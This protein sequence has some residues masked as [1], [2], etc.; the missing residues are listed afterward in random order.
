[1]T[2]RVLVTPRSLSESG[3]ARVPELDLL[4]ARGFELVN[5]PAGR[6]PEEDELLALLPGFSYDYT[7]LSLDADTFARTGS[8]LAGLGD[9]RCS[10]FDPAEPDRDAPPRGGFDLVISVNALGAW[11]DPHGAV[12]ALDQPV[13]STV[14]LRPAEMF[15]MAGEALTS[16]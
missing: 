12:A 10:L 5:G 1:M 2:A 9:V 3:L 4:R 8:D 14:T 6:L 16:M 13:R 15:K 11:S 7:V